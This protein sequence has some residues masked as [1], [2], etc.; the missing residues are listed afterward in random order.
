MLARFTLPAEDDKFPSVQRLNPETHGWLGIFDSDES[1]SL[2]F[3]LA[4]RVKP[5]DKVASKSRVLSL[6]R[7][8]VGQVRR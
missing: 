5:G 3:G 1:V 2:Y 4:C 6:C 8:H 7:S